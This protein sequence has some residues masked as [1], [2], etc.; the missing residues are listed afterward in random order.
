[1]DSQV[2]AS[3]CLDNSKE[4]FWFMLPMR[5]SPP[6][7]VTITTGMSITSPFQRGSTPKRLR[8]VSEFTTTIMAAPAAWRVL[9]LSMNEQPPRRTT[10]TL[11][12]Y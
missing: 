10:T 3:T 7:S 12:L 6:T 5:T 1:M 11:P 4:I 9:A 8:D 2:L